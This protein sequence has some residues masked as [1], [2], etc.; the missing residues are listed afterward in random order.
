VRSVA[1]ADPTVLSEEPSEN[2]EIA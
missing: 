1:S 2:E